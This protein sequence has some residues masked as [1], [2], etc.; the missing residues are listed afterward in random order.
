MAN[1]A[2]VVGAG[3]AGLTT[4]IRLAADGWNVQVYEKNDQVGGKM[5]EVRADGFRW[6]TGPSVITM[7]HVFEE[8][9][10]YAGRNLNDYLTLLPV[11]PLTRY[12]YPDGSVLNASA[13]LTKMSVEI[14]QFDERDIEG[15]LRYL[16]YA[17]K[18]HRITGPV[19]IYNRPP[20]MWDILSVPPHE[21]PAVDPLRTMNGAIKSF[22]RSPQMR[23]LLGRFATYTGASPYRAPATLNVIAHVELNGGVWYPQGG[24]YAIAAALEKL[25]VELGVE[26]YTGC[27][28]EQISVEN[29][30]VTGIVIH[31]GQMI[32]ADAIV[33]NFDVALVY[34]KMLPPEIATPQRLNQ[35]T[36]VEPSCSGFIML[37]GVEGTH[38]T[39]AHHNIFFSPDYPAEFKNIFEDGVPP[40]D[41]TIYVTATSKT[42][43]E[44]APDGCENWFVLV[45]APPLGENYDWEQNVAR[46]RNV[47]LDKLAE[48][49]HDVRDSIRY[50]QILTPVDIEKMTGAR[51]GA[52]YG[53]SSNSK[54]AAF[55]RPH[56]R[57]PDVQALYFTGGTTHPGG[58]VPMVMLSGKS[59]ARMIAE[60]YS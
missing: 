13:D 58:G 39:L 9:F 49:G 52:L 1:N 10:A 20:K 56:N 45:N 3:I 6:D 8:L 53:A 44:H 22:V 28:V 54:W 31:G 42:D 25:A 50:E 30:I 46:Y 51:R 27:P 41:P 17:A 48:Y 55:K 37:L 7:R 59:A 40:Y 21:M 29:G 19:F 18:I 33:T 11:D 15:Y 34:E 23:Q 2:V 32:N 24:I 60:D 36:S 12:F 16:S 4:A 47:V 14:E 26:I 43:S 38:E 35:L 57:A 5:G